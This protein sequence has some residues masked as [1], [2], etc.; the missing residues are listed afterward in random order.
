MKAKEEYKTIQFTV[1]DSTGLLLLNQPPSNLMDEQFFLELEDF[2]ERL[3]DDKTI[4][5]LVISGNGRHFSSGSSPDQLIDLLSLNNDTDENFFHRNAASF[6]YFY[7]AEIPVISAIKGVCIGSAMELALFSHFRFCGEDA[8]LGLPESTFGLMPG[9]GGISRLMA[10]SGKAATIELVLRGNMFAAQEALEYGIA[11]R[12]LSKK[13]LLKFAL[14][15]AG[16]ISANYKK[17]KKQIYLER[18]K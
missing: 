4:K 5:A 6:R 10:I 12:I 11:D 13:E 8:V 17:E 18:Y 16:S 9:I 7:E 3:K 15:F 14:D 2:T 1:S